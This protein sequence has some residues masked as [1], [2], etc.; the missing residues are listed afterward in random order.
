MKKICKILVCFMLV[1]CTMFAFAACDKI[2][3][4]KTTNDTSSVLSNGGVITVRDGY[5][6]FVNGTKTNDGKGNKGNIVQSAIYKVAVDAEQNIV[7]DATYE[8]VVNALVGFKNGS[9][10]AFGDYIYYTTPC[11]DV[12]K[13]AGVL[14]DKTEFRRYDLVNHES[15]LIYTTKVS[16]ENFNFSYYKQGD[17]LYLLVHEE[18]STK[19]LR[20]IKID[21]EMKTVFVKTSVQSTMF[22]K[23]GGTATGANSYAYYTLPADTTS[24]FMTGVRVYKILPNGT[25][26]VKISE[27]KAVTLDSVVGNKLIYLYDTTYYFAEIVEGE[28]TITFDFNV[29]T[30][31]KYDTMLINDD[32][33]VLVLDGNILRKIKYENGQRVVDKQIYLVG[34]KIKIVGMYDETYL[35]YISSD[36]VY[37]ID[38]V[39]D[40]SVKPIGISATTLATIEDGSRMLPEIV[41]DYLYGF[42]K[43][44]SSSVIYMYRFALDVEEEKDAER[45]GVVE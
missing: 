24:E 40:T 39:S 5:M 28:Q 6:Y 20:S 7:E 32:L 43:E 35:V 36:K 45:I 26:N 38:V 34:T 8:K 31:N 19:T 13:N 37:K 17:G 12:N 22:S 41:G 44:K 29:V 18:G 42:S 27:G 4:S 30:A 15:Q 14:F 11:N 2:N 23:D 16:K 10:Y 3:W 33:S 25:D 21:T 1:F 9:I